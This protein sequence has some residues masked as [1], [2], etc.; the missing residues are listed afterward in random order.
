MIKIY[1]NN[2]ASYPSKVRANRGLYKDRIKNLVMAFRKAVMAMTDKEELHLWA[3]FNNPDFMEK[4]GND[5][6]PLLKWSRDWF[7]IRACMQILE[8]FVDIEIAVNNFPTEAERL[9]RARLNEF[10]QLARR[11]QLESFPIVQMSRTEIYRHLAEFPNFPS[12]V[13]QIICYKFEGD[14]VMTNWLGLQELWHH[15]KGG[16]NPQVK[17]SKIGH[18]PCF[19]PE[20]KNIRRAW[21]WHI[22]GISQIE[23]GRRLSKDFAIAMDG[24]ELKKK[25]N[26]DKVRGHQII[27]AGHKIVYG[28]S[29][30]SGKETNRVFNSTQYS[31][32]FLSE[33]LSTCQA[34]KKGLLKS[35]KPHKINCQYYRYV[36]DYLNRDVSYQKEKPPK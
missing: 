28:E 6:L 22:Q 20:Y 24:E 9:I 26:R 15:L 8:L 14:V 11:I 35:I 17:F 21:G 4:V 16:H 10:L 7:T 33:H 5:L 12:R 2:S 19:K 31:I 1:L 27:D 18:I 30:P 36:Y 25:R 34:C 3:H 32:E 23:I 13:K 29:R